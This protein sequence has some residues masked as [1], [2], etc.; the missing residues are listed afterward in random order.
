MDVQGRFRAGSSVW[1]TARPPAQGQARA[2]PKAATAGQEGSGARPT[3][4]RGDQLWPQLL[5]HAKPQVVLTSRA[6]VR[7]LCGGQQGHR[8]QGG[9]RCGQGGAEGG[10]RCEATEVKKG[11]GAGGTHEARV[12]NG[13]GGMPPWA[14]TVHSMQQ[15]VMPAPTRGASPCR[16]APQRPAAQPWRP[17]A[18]CARAAQPWRPAAACALATQPLP[19]APVGAP[20]PPTFGSEKRAACS[21]SCS[22]TICWE[23]SSEGCVS[24][25]TPDRTSSTSRSAC[26]GAGV[27]AEVNRHSQEIRMGTWPAHDPH[28][29]GV[30]LE[31]VGKR[32]KHV[33]ER[34]KTQGHEGRHRARRLKAGRGAGMQAGAEGWLTGA[35][36]WLAWSCEWGWPADTACLHHKLQ[37]GAERARTSSGLLPSKPPGGTPM[38]SFW[39]SMA[40][41]H[42]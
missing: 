29:P 42:P 6:Q 35:C 17:A 16:G 10:S 12:T 5:H 3:L 24:Y 25:V 33:G 9:S 26:T 11:A 1:C 40:P 36:K 21:S 27:A 22:R 30:R 31:H 4:V 13:A 14:L 15:W 34:V 38:S 41:L 2:T 18:A 32:G 7:P 19:A 8:G 23:V 39:R 20:R 28:S 37:H